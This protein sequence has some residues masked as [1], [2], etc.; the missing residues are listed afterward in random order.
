MVEAWFEIQVS[1]GEPPDIVV[2][3]VC[4]PTEEVVEFMSVLGYTRDDAFSIEV[5]G[6]FSRPTRIRCLVDYTALA[7]FAAATGFIETE[8][9]TGTFKFRE[10]DADPPAKVDVLIKP[11]KPILLRD[12]IGSE[13]NPGTGLFMVEAYDYRYAMN[14]FGQRMDLAEP[15]YGWYVNQTAYDQKNVLDQTVNG[16]IN[17]SDGRRFVSFRE[18]SAQGVT[19]LVNWMQTFKAVMELE[20]PVEIDIVDF[21]NDVAA[22]TEKYAYLRSRINNLTLFPEC[23]IAL[24]ADIILSMIGW[25]AVPQDGGSNSGSVYR[26]HKISSQGWLE[27]D[28]FCNLQTR[29]TA[30][31]FEPYYPDSEGNPVDELVNLSAKSP[32]LY[33]Q[34]FRNAYQV[35]VF[36]P[37]RQVEGKT[38]YGNAFV[39]GSPS[40]WK[41]YVNWE[42]SRDRP[43]SVYELV[44]D[45]TFA[46][47]G[48]LKE[49]RPII[50]SENACRV[51][52]DVFSG[53]YPEEIF[54]QPGDGQSP[55]VG[56]NASSY[57]TE[58][59]LLYEFRTQVP[60]N[61]T[62]FAGW[63]GFD[64]PALMRATM[65]KF[66]IVNWR[67]KTMP[68]MR[69][70]AEWSDWIFGPDGDLV[71]NP[72]DVLMS[73]GMV[74]AR[75]VGVGM[76]SIEVPA[77]NCRI[78]PAKIVSAERVGDS[79]NDYWRWK[80]QWVEIE[81]NPIADAPTPYD[82]SLNGYE[83]R[84]DTVTEPFS[85]TP[86]TIDLYAR[87]LMEN[88]N[89]YVS[90][91]NAGNVIAP[92]VLQSDYAAATVEPDPVVA[93]T[94]VTMVEQAILKPR[95]LDVPGPENGSLNN[96][97]SHHPQFW[98]TA[99]NPVRVVCE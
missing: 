62:V 80:Y 53:D 44:A 9:Y 77:P 51:M 96:L 48:I 18:N 27:A 13:G 63:T 5:P 28:T 87:N 92:G 22:D 84:S 23:S 73:H 34:R 81:P 66:S 29:M 38:M 4:F 67:G 24:S 68:I 1:S 39:P 72:R 6:G 95:D 36:H 75:R 8:P 15:N 97:G 19:P 61:N 46:Y 43:S 25:V 56:W 45:G 94:I 21:E 7:A 49:P 26:L 70:V 82:N 55:T 58:V 52:P 98:F 54:S 16:G 74:H 79:G 91:G 47:R 76:M 64:V 10:S 78:F 14:R 50:A 89:V 31:G 42:L 35:N 41:G 3:P 40:G 93:G 86:G 20:Y 30:G 99:P 33:S 60:Y 57:A 37:Y 11:P 71:T 83:R 12:V 90:S 59:A 88:G 65:L 17:S 2:V 69:T 85:E 32:G